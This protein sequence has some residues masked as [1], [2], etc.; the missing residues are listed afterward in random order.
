MKFVDI[1]SEKI[2]QLDHA[3]L[4]DSARRYIERRYQSDQLQSFYKEQKKRRIRLAHSINKNKQYYFGTMLLLRWVEMTLDS[5]PVLYNLYDYHV[6]RD[7]V[8]WQ[9]DEA[10]VAPDPN[11]HFSSTTQRTFAK[12]L[13]FSQRDVEFKRYLGRYR[14]HM[15]VLTKFMY[16]YVLECRDAYGRIMDPC[17]YGVPMSLHLSPYAHQLLDMFRPWFVEYEQ[18]TVDRD[19]RYLIFPAFTAEG[20]KVPIGSLLRTQELRDRKERLVGELVSHS[21]EE[22]QQREIE[23][24]RKEKAH[25]E[26]IKLRIEK[27]NKNFFESRLLLRAN[28]AGLHTYLHNAI[29]P[30]AVESPEEYERLRAEQDELFRK[31]TPRVD[32]MAARIECLRLDRL[33]YMQQEFDRYARK[34]R[35][36][37]DD[38]VSASG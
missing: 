24:I 38:A 26:Y 23:E 12:S 15:G 30:I 17:T 8:V 33:H 36:T 22:E 29:E 25:A 14:V 32:E 21:F 20:T 31:I 7:M 27:F 35:D 13:E 4:S 34:V 10:R 1:P 28:D 3:L 9:E 16:E 2:D 6:K 37:S 19:K 5:C 11:A 18:H